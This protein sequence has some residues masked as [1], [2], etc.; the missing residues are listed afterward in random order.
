MEKAKECERRNSEVDQISSFRDIHKKTN[1]NAVKWGVLHVVFF[2]VVI[3]ENR[4]DRKFHDEDN[5]AGAVH[6]RG[7]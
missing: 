2:G 3:V 5:S 6:V 1:S 4:F 7:A